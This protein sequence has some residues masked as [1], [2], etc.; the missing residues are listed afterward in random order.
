MASAVGL[1][2]RKVVQVLNIVLCGAIFGISFV[3]KGT[4][5]TKISDEETGMYV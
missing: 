5:A 1:R 3:A 2:H 4:S